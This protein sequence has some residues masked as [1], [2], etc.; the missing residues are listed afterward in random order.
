MRKVTQEIFPAWER[1]PFISEA[2][3]FREMDAIVSNLWFGSNALEAAEFYVSV[4]KK[5]SKIGKISHYGKAGAEASGMPEGSISTVEFSLRGQ[6]FVGINGGPIFKLSPAISFA[7]ECSGQ[8][9]VDYFWEKLSEGGSEVRCGWLTDKFGVSWQIFPKILGKLL[10][11]KNR[12]KRELVER[13]IF[14]MAKIDSKALKDAFSG[15]GASP[16]K[17]RR[18][19]RG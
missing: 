13:A 16:K 11:S 2:S 18:K 4:F 17:A 15:K 14:S 7:V 12:E 1:N 8:R 10:E 3:R 6:K 9:E 5:G 19:I